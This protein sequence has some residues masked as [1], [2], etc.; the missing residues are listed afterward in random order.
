MDKNFH[1]F[2]FKSSLSDKNYFYLSK[3]KLLTKLEAY[4]ISGL[5]LE[6]IY[7]LL[8]VREHKAVLGNAVSNRSLVYSGVP[9]G[10]VPVPLLFIIFFQRFLGNS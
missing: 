2:F 9:Q 7:D 5:L 6:W 1:F 10:S 8:N 4:G 3:L